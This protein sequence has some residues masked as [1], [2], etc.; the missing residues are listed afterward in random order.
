LDFSGCFEGKEGGSPSLGRSYTIP[1]GYGGYTGY[2]RR[3]KKGIEGG[4]RSMLL[5]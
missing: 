3:K 2:R 1:T 5:A 4:I